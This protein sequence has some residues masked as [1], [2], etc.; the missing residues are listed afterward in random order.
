[1]TKGLPTV[2]WNKYFSTNNHEF[3]NY[4]T[5]YYPDFFYILVDNIIEAK[6][7]ELSQLTLFNFDGDISCICFKDEYDLVLKSI[8]NLCESIELYEVCAKIHNHFKLNKLKTKKQ[9]LKK[10]DYAK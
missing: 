3:A 10:K 1:M 4:L 7:K 8:M 2:L 6:E 9:S 5:R